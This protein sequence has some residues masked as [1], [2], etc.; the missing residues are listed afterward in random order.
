MSERKMVEFNKEKFKMFIVAYIRAV[1]AN[2]ESF[3]FFDDEYLTDY[4][5]YMIAYM[6]Q[7]Y[8]PSEEPVQ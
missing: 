1:E 6:T 4:A 3:V 8:F 7:K 2:E 5:K